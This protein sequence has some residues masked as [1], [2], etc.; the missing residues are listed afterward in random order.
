VAQL[1]VAVVKELAGRAS[2]EALSKAL[3]EVE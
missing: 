2:R 3:S 1:A